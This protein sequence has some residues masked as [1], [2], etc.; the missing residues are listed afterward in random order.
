MCV[1][2]FMRRKARLIEKS[3]MRSIRLFSGKFG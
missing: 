3:L 1:A 2:R